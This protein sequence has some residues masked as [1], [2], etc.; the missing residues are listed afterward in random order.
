MVQARIIGI[1]W[2][3]AGLASAAEAA[4]PVGTEFQVNGYTSGDQGYPVVCRAPA[5][6]FV[7]AWEAYE[8]DGDGRAIFARRFA[9]EGEALGS[10]FQVNEFTLQSQQ[11]PAIAC[12]EDGAF[13]VVWESLTQDGSSYGVF[14]RRFDGEGVAL[15]GEFQVNA[16]TAEQQLGAGVCAQAGGGFVVTWYS[17]EQEGEA[18][19]YGVFA[20]RFDAEGTAQEEF[21]VA[22]YTLGTQEFPAVACDDQGDFVVVWHADQQDGD[23]Y[24]VFARRFASDGTPFGEEFQVNSYTYYSQQL[25]AVAAGAGGA[26]VV[27]W[28][29]YGYQ[30]GDSYGVFAR[31]F[32]G[33]GAPIGD[34]FQVN[35]Y[36]LFSQEAPQIAMSGNGDFIIAWSSSHD[37]DGY[38]V[39]GQQFAS[40][41]TAAGDEFQVNS[42]TLGYQGSFTSLGTVLNVGADGGDGF[43]V[44]WQSV[45]L[46]GASQDGDGFG[47]FGQRLLAETPAPTTPTA[48]TALTATPTPTVSLT[49]T[50]TLT[51][52]VRLCPGDVD[53]NGFVTVAEL[54]S[55]VR[56]ALGQLPVSPAFDLDG[57][58]V[59]RIDEILAAVGASMGE[60]AA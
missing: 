7:V 29:T 28:E 58:G 25:P 46:F 22:S 41:G 14:A 42:Y 40:D 26:F 15:G 48:T 35:S 24:G 8:Q 1:L 4:R 11:L 19:S 43:V 39:F 34:D 44:V 51:P 13:V 31:R 18:D 30:D 3:V 53:R 59:V 33:D 12:G 50:P 38:G 54:I 16:Y 17:F 21:Q 45:D 9:T 23:S 37:G 55:G 49:A 27:V 5:G 36:T 6:A 20:R 2:L 57:N 52:T 60:C 47:V 56:I 10:E 32:A